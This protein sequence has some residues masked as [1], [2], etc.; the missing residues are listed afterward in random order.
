MPEL[1]GTPRIQP[2]YQAAM[3]APGR[4]HYITQT[5]GS[6]MESPKKH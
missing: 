4:V 1:T 5:A 6:H 2:K 3:G